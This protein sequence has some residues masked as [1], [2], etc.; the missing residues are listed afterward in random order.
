MILN[1]SIEYTISKIIKIFLCFI[2]IVYIHIQII[3]IVS[4]RGINDSDHF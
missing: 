2:L 4:K 3:Q 1:K